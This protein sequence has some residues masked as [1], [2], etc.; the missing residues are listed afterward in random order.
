MGSLGGLV[1]SLSADI[2]RFQSDMGKAVK[3][4][5][6]SSNDILHAFSTVKKAALGALGVA[7]LGALVHKAAEE[8][9]KYES[10]VAQLEQRLKTTNSVSGYTSA[11]LLEMAESLQKVTTF[12]NEAVTGMH[13][14]L[15]SF[16][17]IRGETFEKATVAILDLSTAL[18]K[19]LNSAA[20][21]VG[22][23]LQNPLSGM[24]AL[25]RAGVKLSS[26]QT[27]QIKV[28]LQTGEVAKA[29]GVILDELARKFGGSAVAA[30]DTFGG[31]LTGLKNAIGDLL[32]VAAGDAI[33]AGGLVGSINAFTKAISD[34][35]MVLIPFEAAL[36]RL[37]M[38]FDNLG[39]N[40]ASLGKIIYSPFAYFDVGHGK[41]IYKKFE[42]WETAF[43]SRY[44]ASEKNVQK[45]ANLMA[46]LDE[47]GKPITA[48]H[49]QAAASNAPYSLSA[50]PDG[51][52]SALSSARLASQKSY[53][54]NEAKILKQA[55]DLKEQQNQ[56]AYS[57]G[58]ISYQKYLDTKHALT[59][60]SLQADIDSKKKEHQALLAFE[61]E[62][63]AEKQRI[64]DLGG[65]RENI[66]KASAES[67]KA[68]DEVKKA[69]TEIQLAEGKLQ[70][71]RV[72]NADETKK[73]N[74][75]HVK[76]LSDLSS[77]VLELAG[78]YEKAS[79]A[80]IEFYRG[81][82]DYKQLTAAEK[83]EK[84]RID[85]Y[86]NLM[87][88]QKEQSEA[89]SKTFENQQLTGSIPDMFGNVA[90]PQ[91]DLKLQYDQN[92]AALNDEIQR[93]D[94]LYQQDTDNY[95]AALY[96]KHLLDQKYSA[97]QQRLEFEKWTSIGNIVQGQMGQLA[98]M[99]NKQDK[100]QF[101]MWKALAIG[102]AIISSALAVVGILAASSYLGPA[103]FPLAVMA[104][105]IGAAQVG[106]IAGQQYPGRALGGAVN[107]GD[108]YIVGERGPELFT[109]GASGMITANDKIGA[110]SIT[111]HIA[112]DA[113]GADHGVEQK[114]RVAMQ[115]AK[116][117]SLSAIYSDMQRGGRFA[118]AS[119]RLR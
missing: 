22:K 89:R 10:A 50:I 5:Q 37:A 111:Q 46:G 17:N 64:I 38:G 93:M 88:R 98:S 103:A 16:T 66:D 117:A 60:S 52:S 90:S 3:T 84:D 119:G 70:Q 78:Q 82:A 67:S 85:N 40:V 94:D 96:K 35:K 9:I 108:T 110:S 112:I 28:F 97:D 42:E 6:K 104:G 24:T 77:Q 26:Q 74:Y 7:S 25:Q 92:I 27:E 79:R 65:T 63:Q 39:A 113:R 55:N 114:I 53:Y 8:F 4:A 18:H 68:S 86:T 83:A 30:R 43:T 54:D 49:G 116:E 71:T 107:A 51:G 69:Y 118:R 106:I 23:A 57:W 80:R 105:A 1:V 32:R 41:D 100:R 75:D 61:K 81:S 45:M 62:V 72:S 48:T 12:G 73:L 29:Q 31:A 87:A 91:A 101:E 2:A 102:Q 109:P 33:E 20:L 95:S 59:I 21:L 36:T 76:N 44:F 14:L 47:S 19:D 56:I 11:Q 99:M 115:Q 34:A 15:L 58:L 13:S